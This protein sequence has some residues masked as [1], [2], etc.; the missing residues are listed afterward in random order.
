MGRAFEGGSIYVRIPKAIC[1]SLTRLKA[2]GVHNDLSVALVGRAASHR[3]HEFPV[4]A[5]GTPALCP[6]RPDKV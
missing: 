6:D 2:F 5:S 4:R 1:G 3:C